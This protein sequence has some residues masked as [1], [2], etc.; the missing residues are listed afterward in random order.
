MLKENRSL[1]RG[2]VVLE[3]LARHSAM[4]L[5]DIHRATGLPKSTLRRLLATMEKRRFVRRSLA[6]KLYRV[7][8]NL[9]DISIEPVTPG[10]AVVADIA[11]PH[12]LA[13]TNRIG[14][15]SDIHVME[16]NWM[17]I[18]EST[19]SA[20]PFSLYQTQ[21]DH[22]VGLFYSATGLVCLG[23][24]DDV[25]V[26]ALF[27]DHTIDPIY[28]ASFFGI[29][30]DD[31]QLYLD[32]VR[33]LGYGQRFTKTVV[34][35][36]LSAI[37]LPLYRNNEIWGAVPLLWP[38]VFMSAEEFADKYLDDLTET[39]AQIQADI[40]RHDKQAGSGAKAAYNPS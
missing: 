26:R 39:V 29:S 17:R 2:L 40:D 28:Q 38:K 33:R 30:W 23:E 7:T 34:H 13:L 3:T 31:V 16:S 4:S 35:D 22:K 10:V 11:L 12:V 6:D 32:Q 18:V 24:M 15:P 37:A 25:K 20:S 14:W 21:I 19:R 27:D 9:P 36:K 5:T 1:E 8:V